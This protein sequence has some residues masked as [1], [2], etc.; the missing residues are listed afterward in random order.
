[1]PTVSI[2]T[3]NPMFEKFWQAFLNKDTITLILPNYDRPVRVLDLLPGDSEDG[4]EGMV[5]FKFEEVKLP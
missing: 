5:K 4:C 3:T 1:M 2:S